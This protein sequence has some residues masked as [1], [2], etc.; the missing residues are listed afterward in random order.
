MERV[1]NEKVYLD[2]DEPA[3]KIKETPVVKEKV[4]EIPMVEEKVDEPIV[5]RSVKVEHYDMSKLDEWEASKL[6]KF[7]TP[8][9]SDG[10]VI[11]LLALLKDNTYGIRKV[12][13]TIEKHTNGKLLADDS[14]CKIV[15]TVQT[16]GSSMST[17][18]TQF[19]K[20]ESAVGRDAIHALTNTYTQLVERKFIETLELLLNNSNE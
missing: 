16:V 8:D 1:G 11:M 13:Y 3:E 18:E 14:T 10:E 15:V 4:K 7:L 6:I 17:F 12:W 2:R 9:S 5:L 19:K 20:E